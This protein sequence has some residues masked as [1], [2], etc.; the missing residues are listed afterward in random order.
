VRWK[1]VDINGLRYSPDDPH[2]WRYGGLVLVCEAENV[3]QR[4]AYFL[5][6]TYTP[7]YFEGRGW[8]ADP[9]V[10]EWMGFPGFAGIRVGL[11]PNGLPASRFRDKWQIWDGKRKTCFSPSRIVTFFPVQNSFVTAGPKFDVF[12]E[13]CDKK[14]HKL[15]KH[16]RVRERH[17]LPKNVTNVTRHILCYQKKKQM[18]R[19]KSKSE[20]GTWEEIRL[21]PTL[22]E[23]H[24]VCQ[25][26]V[27]TLGCIVFDDSC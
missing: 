1:T 18:W 22:T 11:S 26:T 12:R 10:L 5:L 24:H 17:I 21:R 6:L 20:T 19:H 14:R 23:N 16:F 8:W 15:K 4:I 27:W 25:M 3:M 13:G 9:W 7:F 2:Y